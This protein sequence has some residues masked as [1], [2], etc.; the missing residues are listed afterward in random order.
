MAP[1]WRGWPGVIRTRA[2]LRTS[3]AVG[4]YARFAVVDCPNIYPD[5]RAAASIADADA[6]VDVLGAQRLLWG[7]DV[8]IDT[9]LGGAAR[10]G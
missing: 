4:L 6:A 8:T 3:A 7:C 1:I 2:G 9:G 5:L 10:A